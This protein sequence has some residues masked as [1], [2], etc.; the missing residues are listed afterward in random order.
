VTDRRIEL[1]VEVPGTPEQV[2]QAIATGPGI[3]SWFIPITVED[4]E[5]GEVVFDWGDFGRQ[6]GRVTAWDPPRRF[7]YEDETER[8]LAYEWL[9]EARDGGTC[10]VRLVN[11]GFGHGDDWDEQYDGMSSGWPLFL[12][13]LRLHLEHF[14]DR[15]AVRTAIPTVM[16]AG[17]G[18]VAW[19]AL[20]DRLGVRPDLAVGDR[21]AP[22]AEGAP[23]LAGTVV[24]RH[25]DDRVREYHL[26][27][28]APAP[29]TAFVTAEGDGDQVALSA[30]QY[31]QADVP[32]EVGPWLQ[33]QFASP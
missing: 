21:F 29:G 3:T 11:S 23:T 9:V 33:A 30:Y 12:E 16:V 27:L 26:L 22:T 24:H 19:D 10:V 7:A 18:A 25:V 32:D 31:L 17:P 13:S 2:W 6:T 28:D 20:C 15:P 8:P 14:A 4:H 1:S 5:G